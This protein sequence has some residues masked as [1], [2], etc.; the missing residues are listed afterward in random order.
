MFSNFLGYKIKQSIL[1]NIEYEF[2]IL[3]NDFWNLEK[4]L[5]AANVTPLAKDLIFKILGV[6]A[7]LKKNKDNFDNFL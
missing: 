5:N 7:P 4:E 3:S 1:H 6:N 2:A